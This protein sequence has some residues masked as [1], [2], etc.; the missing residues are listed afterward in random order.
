MKRANP[1]TGLHFK[2]GDVRADGCV[3][4]TYVKTITLPSGFFK[5]KWLSPEAAAR[6]YKSQ[7]DG[8]RAIQARQHVTRRAYLNKVKLESGC[9]DCGY[10]GHPAALDFDHVNPATKL[11][12]ISSRYLC[13]AWDR[14]LEEISK[15]VVRCAN[16]HRIKSL[17]SGDCRP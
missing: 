8:V 3:F 4:L 17:E 15:C 6:Q 12:N 1:E 13:V 16:C 7:A 10:R 9:V 2:R 5:E 14:M 11:F